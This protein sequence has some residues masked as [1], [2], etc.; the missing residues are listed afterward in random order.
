[1][2]AAEKNIDASKVC[3]KLIYLLKR[4]NDT[5]LSNKL[6]HA[7]HCDFNTS[8]MP[9]FMSIG[10]DGMS[11]NQLAA[12]I[13]VTKQAASKTIKELEKIGLV[14][15]ERSSSDA[16]A[17]M[18]Y[19]TPAGEEFYF[20]IKNQVIEQEERYKKLVGQKNYDTAMEVLQKMIAYH[21]EQNGKL[22]VV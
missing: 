12:Q 17:V 5:W 20:H 4:L 16:R 22:T 7:H 1:M 6:C 11:N 13:N 21:E 14:R 19:Y 3:F 8:H 18:L 10:T 2:G 9:L 15:S